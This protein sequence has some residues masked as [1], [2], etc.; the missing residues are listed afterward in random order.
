MNTCKNC[1][2]D[3]ENNITFCTLCNYPIHGTDEEQAGFIAKQVMDKSDVN[4]AV[5]RLKNAR[6]LLF[7]IC[8]YL[9][10]SPFLLWSIKG[11]TLALLFA[12]VL[13]VL[14]GIVFLVFAVLSF[15]KPKISILIP[16]IGISIY[17]LMLFF[18]GP[19]EYFYKG[20]LWKVII[21]VGL[22]YG[23]Y[24][25]KKSDKILKNNKY[26]ASLVGFE[27]IK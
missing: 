17:Y 11:M 23:Y 18:M 15:K 25:V 3:N 27:K 19:Y 1:K 21:L 24:S 9:L 12:T 5:R 20:V 4:D 7:L 16:L 14:L 8:G 26:L 2:T 13:S 22:G 10:L 6:I